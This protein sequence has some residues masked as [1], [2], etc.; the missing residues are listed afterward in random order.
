MP[1]IIAT[2]SN[3]GD[4]FSNLKKAKEKLSNYFSLIEESRVYTSEAVDY[5]NQPDFYN[6]VL[7]FETPKIE[8]SSLMTQL[9]AIEAELGR[10]R[11]IHL[12]PRIIDIDMLFFDDH[13]SETE[14]L[15]LPHP[16]LFERSFVILPLMELECFKTLK[17]KYE[18]HTNF[19]NSATVLNFS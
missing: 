6:Q 12:G 11:E 1:L 13:K 15:T 17:K 7:S 19:D 4:R 8:A 2:G 14:H 18:F 16:K 10:T 3:L 9:L 5:K